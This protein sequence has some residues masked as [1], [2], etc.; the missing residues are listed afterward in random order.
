[1][2]KRRVTAIEGESQATTPGRCPVAGSSVTTRAGKNRQ[3][4]CVKVNL[5]SIQWKK[6][7]AGKQQSHGMASMFEHRDLRL[8][9]ADV[10]E[11]AWG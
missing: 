11:M 7:A 4:L 3:D 2:I 1:M 5:G 8:S 9:I 10:S 6:P